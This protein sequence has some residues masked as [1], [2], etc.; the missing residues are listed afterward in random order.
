MSELGGNATTLLLQ[1]RCTSC[2]SVPACPAAGLPRQQGLESASTAR[3]QLTKQL[4]APLI[5]VPTHLCPQPAGLP[6]QQEAGVY[7]GPGAEHQ[8]AALRRVRRAPD[9]R[10]W[11]GRSH[12][13]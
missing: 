13:V 1:V 10:H 5:W 9:L 12:T 2:T 7:H 4:A 3:L 8:V 11:W 6:G